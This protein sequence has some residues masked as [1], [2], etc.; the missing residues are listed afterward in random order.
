MARHNRA[1][2]DTG[3]RQWRSA[4]GPQPLF[5]VSSRRSLRRL[6]LHTSYTRPTVMGGAEIRVDDGAARARAQRCRSDVRGREQ[7]GEAE[8]GE[9]A[10][11]QVVRVSPCLNGRRVLSQ[12]IHTVSA[13]VLC[14]PNCHTVFSKHVQAPN[15]HTRRD[16]VPL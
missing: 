5:L 1:L 9:Q 10:G 15:T 6:A 13:A 14:T 2:S 7:R 3:R 4:L 12:S 8:R 11:R 16:P